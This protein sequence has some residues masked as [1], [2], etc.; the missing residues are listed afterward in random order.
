MPLLSSL[1]LVSLALAG[2]SGWLVLAATQ[3]PQWFQR[4]GIIAP[5]RFLSLHLD[6]VMM[7]LF[8]VAIDLVVPDRPAWLTG[9]LAFGLVL[10]PLLFIPLAWSGDV[11][12]YAA[13]RPAT[14]LSFSATSAGLTALAV[15]A[16]L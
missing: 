14:V 5:R 8:L 15:Y 12:T 13:Y 4:R 2:I 10:N 11:T 1:G 9:V 6:W 7:G 16:L 3:Q